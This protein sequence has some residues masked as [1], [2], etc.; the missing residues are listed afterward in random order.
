MGYDLGIY[1]IDYRGVITYVDLIQAGDTLV[2]NSN[3]NN[4]FFLSTDG[5]Y[6]EFE[7]IFLGHEKFKQKNSRIN[8]SFLKTPIHLYGQKSEKNQVTTA[9]SVTV[10]PNPNSGFYFI[11][12]WF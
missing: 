1:W 10:N 9:E 2:K 12:F 5:L 11:K 7:D 4:R 8:I 3:L 6:T